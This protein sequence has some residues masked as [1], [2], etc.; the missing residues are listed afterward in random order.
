MKHTFTPSSFDWLN[1][2][3]NASGEL[4][5]NHVTGWAEGPRSTRLPNF[6]FA[7]IGPKA[8]AM[9]CSSLQLIRAYLNPLAWPLDKNQSLL[10]RGDLLDW[11]NVD[12]RDAIIA[13]V[14][15]QAIQAEVRPIMMHTDVQASYGIFAGACLAAMNAEESSTLGY[16]RLSP[17][18][19]TM[20]T[21]GEQQ[22]IGRSMSGLAKRC[23][24]PFH[25][26]QLGVQEAINPKSAW[27]EA[28][29]LGIN[30]LT[31]AACES[32]LLLL[33]LRT[34][35]EKVDQVI[36]SVDL[37]VL[38]EAYAPGN[39]RGTS[40][41]LSLEVLL[42]AVRWLAGEGSLLGIE[43]TGV[44]LEDGYKNRRPRLAASFTQDLLSHW[45]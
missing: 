28:V 26:L 19:L 7:G 18:L 27:I 44:G 25:A 13:E 35:C 24:Q 3:D 11:A 14:I 40:F 17:V 43:M 45:F 9:A 10:D 2:I 15:E 22:S 38:S 41:G 33:Y 29:A 16:I 31:L 20:V 37:D 36:L 8:G 1:R 39:H 5:G 12:I 30:A 4:V 42:S 34:F 23:G 21:E 32:D 6:L